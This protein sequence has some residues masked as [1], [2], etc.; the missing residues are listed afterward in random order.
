MGKM[1]ARWLWV[2]I[3]SAYAGSLAAQQSA[4]QA[5]ISLAQDITYSTARVYPMLATAQGIPG[6]DGELEAPSEAFRA[7][8]LAR[9]QQW[10]SQLGATSARFDS[11]TSLVDRDDAALLAASLAA[12]LNALTVYQFDRKDYSAAANNVVNAVFTQFEYLPIPGQ[13]GATPAELRRAWSDITARLER[14]PAYLAAARA[15]VTMPCHLFG[16]VGAKQ[17][18]GAPDFLHGALTDAARSQLGARSGAYGRF[19]KA[20]DAALAAIAELKQYIDEHAASW[21]ENYAIGRAAYDRMLK[22]EQLLPFDAADIERIAYDE[23]AHGWA[24][25]G[26]LQ[27]ISHQTGVPVGAPSGGGLAP[28]ARR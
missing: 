25:E 27:N 1:T 20:R 9:L 28:G 15:L 24:E 3:L 10:K 26:W 7:A 4:H 5:L 8:Y 6:H 23:L 16:V 14:T 22:E 21:P 2:T 19:L 18:A 12:S 17:L 11:G 13:D